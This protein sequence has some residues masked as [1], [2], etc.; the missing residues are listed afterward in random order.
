MNYAAKRYQ[1][2]EVSVNQIYDKRYE[3]V[4]IEENVKITIFFG[5]NAFL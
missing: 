2:G 3:K 4:E 5:R 1:E